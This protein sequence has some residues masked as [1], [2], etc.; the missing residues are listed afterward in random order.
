MR[1]TSILVVAAGVL[2]FVGGAVAVRASR[3]AQ[4]PILPHSALQADVPAPLEF[5]E[6]LDSGPALRPSAKA[7]A[8]DGKRVRIV[9]FMADMEEPMEGAFYLVPRPIKLD[10]SG[11]GTGDLPL[12]GILVV[13][14]GS[15][16]KVLPQISGPLEGTGVLEVGNRADDHGRV[17]NFRLRLE[18]DH[19]R[20]R[21]R[22]L[23]GEA[24]P[25]EG[26]ETLPGFPY[27]RLAARSTN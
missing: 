10:E 20:W 2:L 24:E 17:S 14:A 6:L 23:P 5:R 4:A 9:G 11:A 7:T 21:S 25:R 22:A 15:E 3:G 1:T 8:L 18:P 13:V 19:S 26:M 16:G 27:R 12:E